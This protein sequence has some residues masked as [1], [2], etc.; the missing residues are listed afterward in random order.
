MHGEYV[1]RLQCYHPNY[2]PLRTTMTR[3]VQTNAMAFL[4]NIQSTGTPGLYSTHLDPPSRSA[5][6]FFLAKSSA[7]NP[8]SVAKLINSSTFAQ[9][10]S[11]S[12]WVFLRC[13]E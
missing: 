3:L 9:R 11:Q 1:S 12:V 2:C 5:R 7:S 10:L 13:S 6:A 4:C 8:T